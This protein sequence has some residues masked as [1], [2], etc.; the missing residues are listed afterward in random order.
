MN[1]ATENIIKFAYWN[2]QGLRI[3]DNCRKIDDPRFINAVRKHDII[4]LAET[5]CEESDIITVEGYKCFQICRTKSKKINRCFGGIAILYKENLKD[6]IKFLGH[7]N[8]DYVWV[9]LSKHFFGI[10]QDMYVCVAY[11]P[12]EYS[13]YYR[14][15]GENALDLIEKD[16]IM[17]NG[18]GQMSLAGDVIAR[19]KN[20]QDFIQSDSLHDEIENA[21]YEVD[22]NL[23]RRNSQDLTNSC[24]RG[25]RLLELCTST[26]LRIMNGYCIGDTMGR[27]SVTFNNSKYLP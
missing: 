19:T 2:V 5:H 13:P 12:P 6:G 4:C 21:F 26:Q 23:R 10:S 1:K 9:K 15:R 14:C 25:K 3:S 18:A 11:I 27:V 17:Y 16:M 8:N 7:G 20:E 24:P 22:E